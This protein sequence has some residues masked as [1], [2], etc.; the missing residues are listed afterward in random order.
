MNTILPADETSALGAALQAEQTANAAV[1]AAQ[2][3]HE[4]SLQDLTK[5][6]RIVCARRVQLFEGLMPE[7]AIWYSSIDAADTVVR[8]ELKGTSVEFGIRNTAGDRDNHWDLVLPF[9]YFGADGAEAMARNAQVERNRRAVAAVDAAA[10]RE[11]AD[12]RRLAE[13]KAQ[14][15]DA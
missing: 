12:R 15:P 8:A 4:D 13:L 7:Q 5:A 14:F 10:A 9:A 11:A 6:L 1:E 2:A 3:A